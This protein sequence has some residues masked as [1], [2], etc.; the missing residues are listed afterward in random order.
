MWIIYNFDKYTNIGRENSRI[1]V[2]GNTHLEG[3]L[4]GGKDTT[5]N[6]GSLSFNDI[7][8]Y[9]KGTN[10]GLSENISKGQKDEN[11]NDYTSQLDYSATDREQIT[12]ATVG[13]GTIT[14]GGKEENPEGL[15][16]DESKA[17][18][19]T[20]DITVNEI[21]INHQTETRDWNEV[22]D[23]MTEHGKNLGKDL[24]RLTGNK[25]NLE[26]ELGNSFGEVYG[27]IEKIIDK[28]LK[29]EILGII[30][31]EATNGGIYGEPKALIRGQE[32][33]YVTTYK[34]VLD[35][36]GKEIYDENGK[37]R[38]EAEV[39]EITPQEYTKLKAE[40]PDIKTSL[41][42]I[43]NT[44]EGAT[45]GTFNGT[46]SPEDLEA[47][48]TG[49]VQKITVHNP[50]NGIVAD[51]IESAVGKVGIMM[52][53]NI[54]AKDLT[55]IVKSDPSILNGMIAHS[56]GTIKFTQVLKEL[57]KTE[58]GRKLIKDNAKL[59]AVAG[60]AVGTKELQEIQNIVGKDKVKILNNKKDILN[61][62]TGN[63]ITTTEKGGHALENYNINFKLNSKGKYER[64]E[65]LKTNRNNIS[66][67]V[68]K[69]NGRSTKSIIQRMRENIFNK[70]KGEK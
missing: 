58:E 65:E 35:R 54:G 60:P 10:I 20:K 68:E 27:E 43:L 6:T 31:T 38:L 62:M 46:L 32:K 28:D 70:K 15:N 23:I 66:G 44:L 18:E 25:Y 50:S 21:T 14:V 12:H 52:N 16:R 48:K 37:I 26:K 56:Q 33:I 7:K 45:E 41:N 57:N 51:L 40:N 59:I 49:A 63:E 55:E 11:S 61:Y 17:Q 34:T 36:N 19:I 24:D 47:L 29:N 4:L 30:P 1:T 53:S 42:G 5:L 22:K 13:A 2:E 39:K 8:D 69:V 3:G 64:P 9:E 67:T